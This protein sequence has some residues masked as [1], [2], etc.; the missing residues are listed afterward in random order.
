MKF[1]QIFFT[2]FAVVAIAAHVQEEEE[3]KEGIVG[4]QTSNVTGEVCLSSF[5]KVVE[6]K[7]DGRRLFSARKQIGKE[8]VP[9]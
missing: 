4:R 8:H 9:L 1:N 7:T 2:V 5:L 3:R 6:I